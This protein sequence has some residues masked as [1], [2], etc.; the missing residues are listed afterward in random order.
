MS[1][2]DDT[3]AADPA[4]T[5]EYAERDPLL[6]AF[7]PEAGE[8]AWQEFAVGLE[9]LQSAAYRLSAAAVY[10]AQDR[11]ENLAAE[12]IV[13]AVAFIQD[14]R[15]ELAQ[16]ESYLARECG[17]D[18]FLHSTGYLPDGR[19]Y[20]VIRGKDRK[21]W[22][23]AA[24]RHDVRLAVTRD[25]G[26]VVDADSGEKVD[27]AEVVARAMDVVSA[28]APKVTALRALGLAADDYCETSP[29]PWSVKVTG[30]TGAEGAA[31]PEAQPPKG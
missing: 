3:P 17:R 6:A 1:D 20:E 7:T 22:D 28:A 16:V 26:N 13:V 18:D 14:Q 23:H 10:A 24:W 25:L 9:M 19:K 27:V 4:A 31:T 21:G 30:D 5:P 12:D 11:R 15:R 29:G 2:T 8:A